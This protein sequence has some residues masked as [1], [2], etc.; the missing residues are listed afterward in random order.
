MATLDPGLFQYTI[1]SLCVLLRAT[2]LLCSKY[3]SM[4]SLGNTSN[5]LRDIYA[6]QNVLPS[7]KPILVLRQ[8]SIRF[9]THVRKRDDSTARDKREQIAQMLQKDIITN[10]ILK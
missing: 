3:T 6:S 2:P 4:L 9:C 8:K 5:L 1:P 7:C 10:N